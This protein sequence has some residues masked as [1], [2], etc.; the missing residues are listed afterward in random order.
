MDNVQD[1]QPR[2]FRR[3]RWAMTVKSQGSFG[4]GFPSKVQYRGSR[5]ASDLGDIVRIRLATFPWLSTA[6]TSAFSFLCRVTTRAT[7]SL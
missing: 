7:T 6:F 5:Q 1:P 3:R 4:N 2:L